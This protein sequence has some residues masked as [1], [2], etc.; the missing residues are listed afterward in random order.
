MPDWCGEV[1]SVPQT[2]WQST[3]V[4]HLVPYPNIL[5]IITYLSGWVSEKCGAAF[6]VPLHAG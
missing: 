4:T 3:G 5:H 6:P 2:A 1:F